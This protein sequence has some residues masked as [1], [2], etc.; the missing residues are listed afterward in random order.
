ME[1]MHQ[2]FC[3]EPGEEQEISWYKYCEIDCLGI[4]L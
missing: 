4:Y 2:N 3:A 1:V